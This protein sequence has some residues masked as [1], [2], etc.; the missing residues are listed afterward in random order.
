MSYS[1]IALTNRFKAEI[2]P[3]KE[4]RDRRCALRPATAFGASVIEIVTNFEPSSSVDVP[5]QPVR[6][7]GTFQGLRTLKLNKQWELSPV[8]VDVAL[9]VVPCWP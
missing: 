3:Y 7:G 4:I 9:N 2:W 5:A 6:T 1:A 8:A